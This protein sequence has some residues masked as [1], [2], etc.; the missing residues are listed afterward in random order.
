[1]KLIIEFRDTNDCNLRKRS[2]INPPMR[3]NNAHCITI[4]IKISSTYFQI[5]GW[6]ITEVEKLRKMNVDLIDEVLALTRNVY[7]AYLDAP[8]KLKRHYL[9]FSSKNCK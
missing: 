5:G 7:Q 8:K 9:G 2:A 6:G 4:N 3:F 1:M